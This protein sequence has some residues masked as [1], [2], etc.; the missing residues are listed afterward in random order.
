MTVIPEFALLLFVK[1]TI[2]DTFCEI[3]VSKTTALHGNLNFY[4]K[5][6][7]VLSF[8]ISRETFES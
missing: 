6:R 2:H 1:F 4:L 8:H 5:G 3:P 7:Q